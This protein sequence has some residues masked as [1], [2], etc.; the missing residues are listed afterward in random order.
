MKVF[1]HNFLRKVNSTQL[2]V[3]IVHIC[4]HPA[5]FSH[6]HFLSTVYV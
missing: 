1:I 2:Q 4:L 3:S 5:V 6:V